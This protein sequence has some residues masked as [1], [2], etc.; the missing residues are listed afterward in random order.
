[1]VTLGWPSWAGEGDA[2]V[3]DQWDALALD[4]GVLKHG[5]ME[6]GDC[7]AMLDRNCIA[8]DWSVASRRVFVVRVTASS[9][10]IY[11][12]NGE[13]IDEPD[14]F[15][16]EGQQPFLSTDGD[17]SFLEE[18]TEDITCA[19]YVQPAKIP[20]TEET[21][22]TG[23]GGDDGTFSDDASHLGEEVQASGD[24][25]GGLDALVG[26][27]NDDGSDFADD[28]SEELA[29]VEGSDDGIRVI[30]FVDRLTPGTRLLVKHPVGQGMVRAT[31]YLRKVCSPDDWIHIV[32]D[33][34]E[35]APTSLKLQ[36]TPELCKSCTENW[37]LPDAEDCPIS[38]RCVAVM[39]D[40]SQ[41][42]EEGFFFGQ[43]YSGHDSRILAPAVYRA[44]T[45]QPQRSR[46]PSSFECGDKVTVIDD[47]VEYVFLRFLILTDNGQARFYALLGNAGALLQS[48]T[49]LRRFTIV[50]LKVG[51]DSNLKVT[52]ESCEMEVV[53]RLREG[54]D[55]A[56]KDLTV[57]QLRN[58]N[59][60]LTQLEPAQKEQQP[61]PPPQQL[62][63]QQPQPQPQQKQQQQQQQ[64]QQPPPP[65]KQR[66]QRQRQQRQQ[67]KQQQ[68]QQPG[69]SSYALRRRDK[70]IDVTQEQQ[71]GASSYG[72]R[73]RDKH[74]DTGTGPTAVTQDVVW[75]SQFPF[76]LKNCGSK[77]FMN[78]L[79]R[80]VPAIGQLMPSV[81]P[82]G[83]ARPEC[84]HIHHLGGGGGC[85]GVWWWVVVGGGHLSH[86]LVT[87]TGACHHQV[88]RR[89]SSFVF[90]TCSQ[91]LAQTRR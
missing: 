1:M 74:I 44:N 31:V 5:E 77:R 10:G 79:R 34:C 78:G 6:V 32:F 42:E 28:K 36:L 69:A 16:S 72:L 62:L 82:C 91:Q 52:G 49:L 20:S 87:L 67:Q 89:L 25:L 9:V 30:P 40:R 41:K 57:G 86:T 80:F 23:A 38:E 13:L 48:P 70:H 43:F 65:P 75:P 56:V 35:G 47:L 58:G 3:T 37:F 11:N 81:S 68:Q 73:T 18:W 84:T 8:D 2:I 27:Y 24:G 22:D 83:H 64:Q 63:L 54:G 26:W 17:H 50:G 71:P 61:Q 60:G 39:P 90:F 12:Q 59:H 55:L 66:Q 76:D 4:Q 46:F 51:S 21:D 29:T 45:T 14:Y 15:V 19:Y 85:G 53:N 88:G 33:D 7:Y